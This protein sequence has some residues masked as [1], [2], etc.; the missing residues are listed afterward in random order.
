[1]IGIAFKMLFGERAKYLMLVT[2]VSFATLLM[3]QG[4]SMFFG[5]LSFSYATASNIRAPIWV[6][7]PLTEQVG[8]NQPLRDTD[9]NRVRSVDGVEW[10]APLYVGMAQARLL[11]KGRTKPVTLVGLDGDTLAGAPTDFIRGSIEA[12]QQTD[13]VVIDHQIARLL[14]SDPSKPLTIG[15][16]FEMNDRRAKVVGVVSVSPGMGGAAYVFTTWDRAKDY[17]PNQR[18]MLTYILASPS[19]GLDSAEV[20][21]TIQ[22]E[23]GLQAVTEKRMKRMTSEW[24]IENSPVPLVVGVIVGIG[25]L[26]GVVVSGQTFYTFVLENTP[27]LGALKAMGASANDLAAMIIAQAFTIGLIGFG[28]GSGLMAGLFSILPKDTVPLL[29]LW[30]VP[31]I[32]FLA[33][34]G[35]CVFV[36][37]ISV[38]RV[39]RIEPAIVFRN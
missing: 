27:S 36:A 13:S 15:D 18:K 7:D 30:P 24:M 34:L 39:S 31:I 12:L 5:I 29:L 37:I 3:T 11:E 17:A 6:A 26:V 4:L 1:M 9:I 38:Y 25:F 22:A 10:A 28:I 35:I 8:D 32:V 21:K 23:T 14:A 33:I 16:V 19:E 2:G 20:A